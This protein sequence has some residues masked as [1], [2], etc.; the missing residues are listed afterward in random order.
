MPPESTPSRRSRGVLRYLL[1]RATL[2]VGAVLLWATVV[3]VALY[4]WPLDPTAALQSGRAGQDMAGVRA[5]LG[6]DRTYVAQY[7]DFLTSRL[8]FDVSASWVLGPDAEPD[9]YVRLD[10]RVPR[11]LL[12]TAIAGG[13]A[14]LALRMRGRL[15]SAPGVTVSSLFARAMPG[16]LLASAVSSL[17]L[18]DRN[19]LGVD[20]N[21][22]L[23]DTS[24][25]SRYADAVRPP[26]AA[27]SSLEAV[28]VTLKWYAPAGVALGLA[29]AGTY[30]V[31][32]TV[33]LEGERRTAYG[34]LLRARG[35]VGGGDTPLDR[36]VRLA[37]VALLPALVSVF[38]GTLLVVEDE[39]A[40]EGVGELFVTALAYED[41]PVVASVSVLFVVVVAA[42]ALVRELVFV[43]VLGDGPGGS[44]GPP[45]GPN[46]GDDRTPDPSAGRL[47]PLRRDR[48][49][50]ALAGRI[51][52][53]PRPAAVWALGAVVVLGVELP[54]VASAFLETPPWDVLVGGTASAFS[55]AGA[56]AVVVPFRAFAAAAADA[57][58]V[59]ADQ[60]SLLDRSTIPNDGYWTGTRYEGTF[61]G[62]APAHAWAL[63]ASLVYAYAAALLVWAGVGYRIYRA[64]YR[65]TSRTPTD[66]ALGRLRRDPMAKLG[67]V[68]VVAF[69]V[70]A[71]FA[72]TIGPAA[73]PRG[74][75][76]DEGEAYL[77]ESFKY[78]DES[79]EGVSTIDRMFANAETES[80]PRS[81]DGDVG[82]M[83]Y[84]DFGRFHPF[85]TSAGGADLFTVMAFTARSYLVVGTLATAAAAAFA[86]GAS[87]LSALGAQT[88]RLAGWV[89]TAVGVAPTFPMALTLG[90][91]FQTEGIGTYWDGGVL[92]AALFG[93]LLWRPLWQ[94]LRGTVD[95]ERSRERAG[96][97]WGAGGT[98]WTV[99]RR[100]VL[101]AVRGRLL[102][103]SLVLYS[104]LLVTTQA[105]NEFS[106]LRAYTFDL[107]PVY[108][109]SR[110]EAWWAYGIPTVAFLLLVL[111][112]AGLGTAI[113]RATGL[114]RE[115]AD[116]AGELGGAAGGG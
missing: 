106:T 102:G 87:T 38:L 33:A 104:G 89:A 99:L 83:R 28:P 48:A 34:E 78:Y 85:G 88:E 37:V 29:L 21:T 47:T 9:K 113:R 61:L 36:N 90:F 81:G 12:V 68:I 32:R 105:S 51:R 20:W 11:T 35:D 95:R 97:V 116:P 92:L 108:V 93:V 27:P 100:R 107:W 101:P 7:L 103:Y 13:V 58:A 71:V 91:A 10:H 16:F 46:Q 80:K 40:V 31:L 54:A 17:L 3:F 8:T 94:T 6:L 77:L 55:D 110:P 112:F 26:P 22:F 109:S 42:A 66:R 96:P 86:V 65:R 111:G 1:G 73:G 45:T 79:V 49:A 25:Y 15:E 50:R 14:A 114:E 82:P 70:F 62:L 76:T 18:D 23:V 41:V 57:A 67:V 69:V 43:A 63:R 24:T 74:P 84:D 98:R 60:P 52:A 72:P 115:D 44:F 39:F 30:L 5:S 19:L 4:V 75:A 53:D 59:V 64:R 2:L 56:G